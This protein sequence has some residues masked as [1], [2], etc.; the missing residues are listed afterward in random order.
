MKGE[1]VPLTLGQ[2]FLVVGVA[3][4]LAGVAFSSGSR[5][6]PAG[7]GPLGHDIGMGIQANGSASIVD[8]L[9][10]S[11]VPDS[12][13]TDGDRVPRQDLVMHNGSIVEITPAIDLGADKVQLAFPLL[14]PPVGGET[15]V[16]ATKQ[17]GGKWEYL[18]PTLANGGRTA[19][20]EASHLSW[21]SALTLDATGRVHRQSK[22]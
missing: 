11:K 13:L 18:T 8:R 2:R 1:N 10:A 21:W 22:G 6:I 5:W 15:V 14:R 7:E 4:A 9:K 3:V 16:I 17:K 12:V 19:I 20:V